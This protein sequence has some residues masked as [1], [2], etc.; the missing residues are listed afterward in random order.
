MMKEKQIRLRGVDS[1]REFVR[2]ASSYPTDNI[3]VTSRD[4]KVNARSILGIFS[5]DLT[6]NVI[7]SYDE[8]NIG[9]EQAL[10]RFAV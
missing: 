1:I 10:A 2:L 4:Q 3:I 6:K 9:F 5:L 7:V 8:K